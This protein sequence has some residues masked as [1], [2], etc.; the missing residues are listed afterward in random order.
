MPDRPARGEEYQRGA[1]KKLNEFFG[2]DK[3]AENRGYARQVLEDKASPKLADVTDK[4]KG[5]LSLPDPDSKH[6]R[7]HWFTGGDDQDEREMRRA[8]REAIDL[9]EEGN[10]PIETFWVW[11][12]AVDGSPIQGFKILVSP[13][14]QRVKVLV[15]IPEQMFNAAYE[16][17]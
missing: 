17:R 16:G 10:L 12:T 1:V 7:A 5:K 11:G 13:E 2:G 15:R 4:A 14:P 9:A 8:Y 3:R 6:F